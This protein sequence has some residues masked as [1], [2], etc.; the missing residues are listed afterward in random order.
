MEEINGASNRLRAYWRSIKVTGDPAMSP[1]L[2]ALG[3]LS[4]MGRELRMHI[5]MAG[6]SVTAKAS[7][8]AE[9]RENFGGRALAR[10]TSN[11]WRMLAPQIKPAPV[12]RQASGRWHIVVG[13]TLREFQAPF[14]DLK[15]KKTPG[16]VARLID[17]ATG[18]MPGWDV[19]AAMLAGG[20][21]GGENVRT[22]SSE[23]PTPEGVS[24]RLYADEAGLDVARL[25]RWRERRGD[26]PVEVALGARGVKLYERDH[27]RAY[28]RARLREPVEALED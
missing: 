16:A 2:T 12:V 19:P 11:Q 5:L 22:P 26:F 14:M 3:N 7:G 4:S 10:A 8:G 25:V 28:V 13:D 17:W 27:L 23:P 20:G 9:N 6:Q 21:G 1:A 24:L 18:G 15:E